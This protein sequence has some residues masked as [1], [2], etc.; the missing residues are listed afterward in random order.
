MNA[1]TCCSS[2]TYSEMA[3]SRRVS[4]SNIMTPCPYGGTRA[5]TRIGNPQPS[6]FRVGWLRDPN[7][8]LLGHA[9]DVPRPSRTP[10]GPDWLCVRL[11]ADEA[12][13]KG[14]HEGR[15]PRVGFV[16]SSGGA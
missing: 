16:D 9:G 3:A 11:H 6:R 1:R 8:A 7:N 2:G 5:K 4:V 10:D 13:K 15:F 12:T 14:P